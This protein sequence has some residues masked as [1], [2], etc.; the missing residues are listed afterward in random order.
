MPMSLSIPTKQTDLAAFG[1]LVAV[2]L[3]LFGMLVIRML[4]VHS[5][6]MKLPNFMMEQSKQ[7]TVLYLAI[8]CAVVASTVLIC[9]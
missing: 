8:F 3:I 5:S 2:S 4:A 9:S 7:H 6:R 1:L